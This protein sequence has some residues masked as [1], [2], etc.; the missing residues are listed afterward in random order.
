MVAYYCRVAAKLRLL[1]QQPEQQQ[2]RR[3]PTMG[4][5]QQP[6]MVNT[7]PWSSS[8]LSLFFRPVR[9]KSTFGKKNQTKTKI[10]K[11]VRA[12]SEFRARLNTIEARGVKQWDKIG[13]S[14]FLLVALQF[15]DS[16]FFFG[17]VS[18]NKRNSSGACAFFTVVVVA[19]ALRERVWLCV[20]AFVGDRFNCKIGSAS[21]LAGWQER[22]WK[23]EH[24]D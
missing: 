21:R 2:L 13:S 6:I 4:L 5:L 14:D 23:R 16:G 24:S 15:R 17:C 7:P 22:E 20:R 18:E 10:V 9:K 3:T 11:Q 8:D 12:I 1:R 19:S